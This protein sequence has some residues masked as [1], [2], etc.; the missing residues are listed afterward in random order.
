MLRPNGIASPQQFHIRFNYSKEE[1]VSDL[2]KRLSEGEHPLAYIRAENAAGFKEAI[3]RGFVLLKF[4]ETQGGTELGFDVDNPACSLD[5]GD[6][7]RNT[8]SV[9]LEGSLK[10]DYVA[11]RIIADVD[12]ATLK[13]TGKLVPT[14]Q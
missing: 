12:L 5:K 13:G 14:D 2:V 1:I 8:G 3:D 9:H 11:V 7:D 4:T 10:L 6:F